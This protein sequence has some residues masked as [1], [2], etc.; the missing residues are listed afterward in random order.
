MAKK[1]DFFGTLRENFTDFVIKFFTIVVVFISLA[2][3]ATPIYIDLH[4]DY[5]DI[6][7]FEAEVWLWAN[8]VCYAYL[9]GI[10]AFYFVRELR[11]KGDYNQLF[12]SYAV[13]PFENEVVKLFRKC[14]KSIHYFG[15]S[16]FMK[17]EKYEKELRKIMSDKRIE[18]RRYTD[19]M[20]TDVL[21][22]IL[23]SAQAGT[24]SKEKEELIRNYSLW[25]KKQVDILDQRGKKKKFSL[26]DFSEKSESILSDHI[27]YEEL[28]DSLNA[29]KEEEVLDKKWDEHLDFLEKKYSM[30]KKEKYNNFIVDLRVAPSWKWGVHVIVVDNRDTIFSFN[31]G[32]G[33]IGMILRNNEDFASEISKSFMDMVHN[34]TNSLNVNKLDRDTLEKKISKKHEDLFKQKMP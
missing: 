13:N 9:L 23:N 26:K 12:F 34:Y 3:T 6:L 25:I 27:H 30:S 7:N 20:S 18:Y 2:I 29:L 15:A 8:A 24:D 11:K 1:E 33:N 21:E 4:K 16:N 19:I 14:K 5:K 10:I 28:I 22:K 32:E 17:S 31:D